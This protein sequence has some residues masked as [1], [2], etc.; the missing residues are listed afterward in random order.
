MNGQTDALSLMT[1]FGEPS[2][3]W[4]RG[5]LPLPVLSRPAGGPRR[6]SA[7]RPDSSR[8]ILGEPML[9]VDSRGR[10]NAPTEA[11]EPTRLLFLRVVPFCLLVLAAGGSCA[12]RGS[13]PPAPF[14]SDRFVTHLPATDPA[15]KFEG[16]FAERLRDAT[17]GQHLRALADL[18]DQ[19]DLEA[20]GR[21]L[22]EQGRDKRA[23]RAAVIGALERTA[24]RQQN[25]FRPT[26]EALVREGDLDYWKPV[27]IVNRIVVE[28]RAEGILRLAD[29]PEVARVLPDWE[30]EAHASRS[31]LPKLERPAPVGDRFQS[32]AI[33]A[34]RADEVWRR[35]YDGA[36]IVVASI[37]TGVDGE[38]EQLR[39]RRLEGSRG[40]YDP[41][42]ASPSPYDSH[43]HGTGVLSLAVGANP[44]GRILGIAPGARWATALGNWRNH[45]SRVRMTLAADWILRVARP[46]V[47]VNA[48]SHNEGTCNAFDLPFI[49]AWKASGIFV[50]FPAGNAGPA[51]RSGEAP[52]DLAGVY[53]A[54]APV[55]SVAGLRALD[56]VLEESSRGPSACGSEGFPSVAAPGANVPFATPGGSRAYGTGA[57]TSFSAAFVGGGAALLLQAQPELFPE[58][59]ERILLETSRDVPPT[60]RD[61]ATGMGAVDLAAALDRVLSWRRE[62]PSPRRSR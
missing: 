19:L 20:L 25:E 53:P 21:A 35:G 2:A 16:D 61:D 51:P 37:D 41:V 40:W 32:W 39:G 4:E 29:R 57:G 22:R 6:L 50:V 54:G 52:A 28:G 3:P 24:A 62:M 60:G 45:Y 1:S 11:R 9:I 30:S 13:R 12:T 36:G 8:G 46:D 7:E 49:S 55:F 44:E 47:L 10:R 59:L 31:E 58:D 56:E 15:R 34:M 26:L 5:V 18:T 23:T 48:W 33:G 17:P 43:G 14:P 42:E 27:A 38:H